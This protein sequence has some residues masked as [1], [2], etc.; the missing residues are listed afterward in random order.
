[1]SENRENIAC[2][3]ASR[4]A[5]SLSSDPQPIYTSSVA[6]YR[7]GGA[8]KIGRR[9]VLLAGGGAVVGSVVGASSEHGY[10]TVQ[11]QLRGPHYAAGYGRNHFDLRRVRSEERKV[12]RAEDLVRLDVGDDSRKNNTQALQ[13]LMDRPTAAQEIIQFPEGV[14]FTDTVHG[15]SGVHW[16]GAGSATIFKWRDQQ[17]TVDKP[18]KSTFE[19][20][21]A[22]DFVCEDFVI[23]GR[24]H[25]HRSQVAEAR[26]GNVEAVNTK[27]CRSF[28]FLGVEV[29]DA[30]GD[31]FDSDNDDGGTYINCAARDMRKDGFHASTGSQNNLYVGCLAERTEGA[32]GGFSL[33]QHSIGY[34]VF[35][36][37]VARDCRRNWAIHETASGR[38]GSLFWCWSLDGKE[39]DLLDGVS[40][41]PLS[42][43]AARRFFRLLAGDM[44]LRE[45]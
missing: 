43:A 21:R 27:Y 29:R 30:L 25:A 36:E 19:F 38:T 42:S 22:A 14:I 8:M 26:Y 15:R 12:L 24:R 1:M 5:R 9:A 34:H 16:R 23:D 44:D 2:G 20:K 37:C 6:V 28:F 35:A 13:A 10:R 33:S 17:F 4:R 7:A 39:P 3:A 40:D 32:R 31:G 11:D 45:A 41:E 18:N